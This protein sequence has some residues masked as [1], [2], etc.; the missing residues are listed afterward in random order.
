M[1]TFHGTSAFYSWLYRIAENVCIDH[2]RKQKHDTEP[3]HLIEERRVTQTHPCPSRDTA[4]GIALGAKLIASS[5]KTGAAVL[6]GTGSHRTAVVA[7]T[8]QMTTGAFVIAASIYYGVK[9]IFG[10]GSD[11]GSG[12]GSG[13]GNCIF[14]H[15]YCNSCA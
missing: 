9:S 4:G 13:S 7:T 10:G 11:N 12:S 5:G 15:Y 2:F 1:N 6:L 14:G 8:A 3:L